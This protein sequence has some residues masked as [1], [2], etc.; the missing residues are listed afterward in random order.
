MNRI[1]TLLQTNWDQRAAGNF[2]FG[3]AGSALLLMTAFGALSNAPL[4]GP[5]LLALFLVAA[6][7]GLVWFELG[8][9]WRA[10]HVFFHPQTSW[11]TREAIVAV[12]L[13]TLGLPAV[14]LNAPRLMV[15]VGIVG[16]V[17]LYCQARILQASKGIPAWREPAIL[18]LITATGLTE[19]AGI[20]TVIL[21]LFGPVPAWL[22]GVLL[23][24]VGARY[25]TWARYRDRLSG[26]DTPRETVDVMLRID[27]IMQRF[28]TMIPLALIVGSFLLTGAAQGWLILAGAGAVFGGWYLKFAIVTRAAQVQGYAIGVPRRRGVPR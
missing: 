17:F 23:V 4:R 28:G 5:S 3:G 22:Q 25:V 16:L 9:P 10:L 14:L 1:G 8:R 19:G 24:L 27:Q 13:F 21:A 6:G 20:L 11:M 12:V 2:I 26:P 15:L 7:L 18:P